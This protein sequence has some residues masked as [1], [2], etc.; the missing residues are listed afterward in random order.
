MA[1]VVFPFHVLY[2]GLLRP[3]LKP[4]DVP[5][6]EVSKLVKQGAKAVSSVPQ[7][8]ASSNLNAKQQATQKK[9]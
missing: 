9:R 6:V 5:D 1:K 7:A 4:F 2:G 3:P 8:K